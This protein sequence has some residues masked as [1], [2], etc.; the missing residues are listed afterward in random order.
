ML[1]VITARSESSRYAQNHIAHHE[2]TRMFCGEIIPTAVLET[3]LDNPKNPY[4]GKGRVTC[5]E[6]L[7]E[8]SN[9]RRQGYKE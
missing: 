9:G 3:G 7:S 2:S 4:V 8:H 1:Y 5:S 6:C